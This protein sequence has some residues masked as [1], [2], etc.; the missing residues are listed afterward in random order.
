MK[1]NGKNYTVAHTG[2]LESLSEREYPGVTGK[3]SGKLFLREELGLTGCEVSMNRLPAGK[4]MT[5]VHAH[6][7]NEEVYIV[8]RGTGTFFVDGDE[9]E[10]REGSVIRI[11][12]SGE[13][14][15]KA[16]AEDLYFIC[17]QTDAGSLEQ[18]T[19]EDG[20]V[21]QAKASWM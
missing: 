19:R 4:G 12:P 17:V 14:A 9:F 6:K 21:V 16:G 20:V 13:R 5:F 1:A 10:V 3:Y 8:L 7:R 15:W 2:K 11:A 18:A